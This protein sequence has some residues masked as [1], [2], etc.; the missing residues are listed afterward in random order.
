M[1][2]ACMLNPS[3]SQPEHA[4]ATTQWSVVIRAGLSQPGSRDALEQ[5]CKTYWFPIYAYIRRRGRNHHDAVDLT[6]GFFAHLLQ[7]NALKS[8]SRESGCFRAFL[9]A[10]VKNYMATWVRF[11]TA[12]RR[13][14]GR[15]VLSIDHEQVAKQYQEQLVDPFTPEMIFERTW[16]ETLLLR[17]GER[18][19]HEHEL[20]GKS[21]LFE[22]IKGYLVASAEK[23]PQAEIATELQISVPAVAMS[24]YRLRQRYAQY[25]REAIGETLA[26]PS[27]IEDELQRLIGLLSY[28]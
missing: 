21:Q 6:Q 20:A 14:G 26:D 24:I 12:A 4:F 3:S 23:I 16:I 19:R 28:G 9:L 22:L 18:L 7:G 25:V 27:E 11:H 8:V 13:G 15:F 5:L 10:C 17:V 2:P 1:P